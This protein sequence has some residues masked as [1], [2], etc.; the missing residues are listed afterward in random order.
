MKILITTDLYS[1]G[2][3]GVVTS[4]RNLYQELQKKGHDIRILTLSDCRRSYHTEGVYYIKT[5]SLGFVYPD[6][7]MP[8]SYK[9]S[10][11]DEIIAWGPDIIHS[12]CEFFSFQFATHIADKLHIPIIHT[13][14]TLYEQYVPYLI[15]NKWLGKKAVGTFIKRRL[16]NIERIIVPTAKVEKVLQSYGVTKPICI[17]P[18]GIALEQFRDEI[19]KNVL[20]E[21]RHILG[22]P[23]KCQI[24]L[25]L[26]RLGIEKNIGELVRLFAQAL[27][28]NQ[29]LVLLIVG[30]G[31]DRAQL[32]RLS[33][34]LGISQ[35]VIFTGMVKP[36]E[37]QIFYQ[38]S[39]VFVSASTSETQGLT[40]L[41]AAANGLPLLC[42]KD[43]CLQ[44][45]LDDG[46]NGFQYSCQEEFLQ[47]LHTILTDESW[48]M[49]AS[50]RS[51]EM[52]TQF[53][54]EQF[55]GIM[56]KVYHT[57]IYS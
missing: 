17:V 11:I 43:D 2:T 33:K 55:A 13:C 35:H 4:I 5:I 6:I 3:N 16:R 41:E 29:N 14:H 56:E 36:S 52:S 49:Q 50:R 46:E 10:L 42:R 31:P 15:P 34:K 12:Q 9:N 19:P 23:D 57:A 27:N 48:R 20:L 40:Y 25:S 28:D 18:T 30:D 44:E 39:D 8:I 45:L 47:D 21:K 37:V 54:R 26:G 53:D 22:I 32:E 38:I 24:V 1:V 51:R 7:R